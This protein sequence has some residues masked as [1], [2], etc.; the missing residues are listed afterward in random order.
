MGTQRRVLV[1]RRSAVAAG[2]AAFACVAITTLHAGPA[3]AGGV[4][5]VSKADAF[6]VQ[7]LAGTAAPPRSSTD[8]GAQSDPSLLT[9]TGTAPTQ[10]VVKLAFTP[11]STYVGDVP[12]LRATAPA[13]TRSVGLDFSA[14]AVRAYSSYVDGVVSQFTSAMRTAV[15]SAKVGA[16]LTVVY[17]GV[18]VQVPADRVRDVAAMP[19]VVAVQRDRVVHT[20]AA[21]VEAT[22][23]GA[24]TLWPNLG[25]AAKAGSGVTIG[26]I[27]TGIWPEHPS[28]K[29]PGTLPVVPALP[30]GRTRPCNFG[31]NPL[32]SPVDPFVCNRKVI[33]GQTFLDTY[34][35]YQ[36][37]V[38]DNARDAD[39]HGTL[40]AASAAGDVIAHAKYLGNDLGA[41]SG[42]A[43]GARLAIYKAGDVAVGFQSDDI[44]AVGQAVADQVNIISASVGA[45]SDNPWQ[46]PLQLAYLDAY[47]NGI[48]IAAAAGNDGPTASSIYNIAPW[49]TTVGAS[50][51]PRGFG[52]TLT[53]TATGATPL[54]LHGITFTKGIA[55]AKPVVDAALVTA[56]KDGLCNTVAP[57]NSLNGKVVLCRR[58][59]EVG[60]TKSKNIKA[61]GAVGMILVTPPTITGP[62]GAVDSYIPDVMLDLTTS[63]QA[64]AFLTAHPQATATWTTGVAETQPANLMAD[65]SS[66]GPTGS[67]ILKPDVVAPGTNNFGP[68]SP[69]SVVTEDGPQ[70]QLYQ[71]YQG[72]SFST[73]IVAGAA[74]LLRQ[75][76]PTWTPGQVKSA[77]MTTANSAV[78][79]SDGITAAGPFDKGSGLVRVDLATNPG[80]T[81]NVSATEF[82]AAQET[83]TG[84]V[85]LNL[86]NVYDD[87]MPD[88]LT[89]TRTFTN[90]GTGSESYTAAVAGI[91]N[92][93]VTPSSFTVAAGSTVTLT[94]RIDATDAAAGA[95][96]T[97]SLRL[98]GSGGAPNAQLP[99]AVRKGASAAQLSTSCGASSVKVGAQLACTA[100]VTNRSTSSVI[101]V[102]DANGTGGVQRVG[103]GNSNVTLAARVPMQATLQAGTLFGYVSGLSTTPNSFDSSGV[104]NFTTPAFTF[105]G[106]TYTRIGITQ[107]GFAV[108]G[109]TDGSVFDQV[110][111][112]T[113]PFPDMAAPNSLLAP[114][115]T[116]LFPGTNPSMYAG[117]ITQTSTGKKWA[118]FEW[119]EFNN[120]GQVERFQ[121]WIGLNGVDDIAYAYDPTLAPTAAHGIPALIGIENDE[122]NRGTQITGYHGTD[123]RAVS[124]PAKAGGSASLTYTVRGTAAGPGAAAATFTSSSLPGSLAASFPITVTP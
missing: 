1:S 54:A 4:G 68:R 37:V 117:V 96:Q 89:V 81:L 28:F 30:G 78:L 63:P 122:G 119:V 15:P 58:G 42:I 10:I 91:P 55:T 118:L 23:L 85:T 29:D 94:V 26:M 100:T 70:G 75:K 73:P 44:A 8:G 35:A 32:T 123:Y 99:V 57:A 93:A 11:V 38:L 115:A 79:S 101:G 9:L 106:H 46:D 103:T 87:S 66:R 112:G 60:A 77:L 20:A 59:V 82:R 13:V 18:A 110:D 48:F 31:D 34:R 47:A 12:G 33:S 97:G 43:P 14:A 88:V 72:T 61:G 80:L 7:G 21:G 114:F 111:A 3:S 105:G 83:T 67:G 62:T 5:A 90:V 92:V 56:Y 40:T 19:D 120:D 39:G 121:L 104:I 74:A 51:G 65:F 69:D 71:G 25:G 64:L 108:P 124:A 98:T 2:V 102:L 17:G 45:T 109:G 49:A 6:V 95:W 50:T 16:R 84:P 76:H 24:T 86:P 107:Y 113:T 53:L 36:G 22:L 52:D 27:D 116:V 41:V